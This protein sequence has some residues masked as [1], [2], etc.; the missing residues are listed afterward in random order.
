[1]ERDPKNTQVLVQED[2]HGVRVFLQDADGVFLEVEPEADEG[3]GSGEGDGDGIRTGD[4]E[5]LRLE[6]QAVKDA[7]EALEKEVTEL[8]Q[9]LEREKAK[10]KNLWEL[11]CAQLA[12][13]DST[14]M[15]KDEEIA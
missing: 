14:L 15:E 3:D 12:E 13:F 8:R 9:K 1:M 11:N 2:E 6:L 4:V 7:Q 10:S 5:G